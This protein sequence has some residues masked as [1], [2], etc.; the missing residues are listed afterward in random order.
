PVEFLAAL[1]P[2][3]WSSPPLQQVGNGKSSTTQSMPAA[4]AYFRPWSYRRD[5][6]FHPWNARWEPVPNTPSVA[7][8]NENAQN[9]PNSVTSKTAVRNRTPRREC[10]TWIRV[11]LEQAAACSI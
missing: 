1:L 10:K 8:E 4:I 9:S 3:V 2:A 11:A 6:C 5:L 7:R